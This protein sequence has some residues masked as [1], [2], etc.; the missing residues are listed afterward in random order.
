MFSSAKAL[1][2]F[3]NSRKTS[4]SR[5]PVKKQTKMHSLLDPSRLR[6]PPLTTAS[7]IDSSDGSNCGRIIG[8]VS[9]TTTT[10]AAVTTTTAGLNRHQQSKVNLTLGLGQQP[11]PIHHENQLN[12]RNVL[13]S[14]ATIT[15]EDNENEVLSIS[16]SQ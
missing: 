7:I 14:S 15:N 9:D 2:S 4:P 1:K 13:K 6:P 3:P 5:T 8:N 16:Q 12:I 10:K 11:Q